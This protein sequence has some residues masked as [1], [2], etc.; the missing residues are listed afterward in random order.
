VVDDDLE[1]DLTALSS[2]LGVWVRG[3]R[4]DPSEGNAPER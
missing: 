2:L 1:T 3:V 4:V